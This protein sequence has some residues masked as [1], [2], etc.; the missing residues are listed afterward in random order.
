[1]RVA[2]WNG[3]QWVDWGT[4]G[5]PGGNSIA[6]TVR[7]NG[8]VSSFGVFT[9]ASSTA[10]NPL[11]IELLAFSGTYKGNHILLQWKTA[12]E[13]NNDFFT[14]EKSRDGNTWRGIG[15]L[16]GGGTTHLPSTYSHQDPKPWNG[17]QYYRLSQTDFDG[18]VTHFPLIAVNV[19]QLHESTTIIVHPNP[20]DD[21]VNI[22]MSTPLK[23]PFTIQLINPYGDVLF[24]RNTHEYNATLSLRNLSA[25]VYIVMIATDREVYR[26]K[27]IRR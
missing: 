12:N 21:E 27:I 7:S 13:L 3:S 1:M 18:G 26:S 15:K 24:T 11:P 19:E 2:G 23:G 16:P 4:N 9:L 22:D 8:N 25:G 17:V 20:T 10:D 6:G 14:L 5:T